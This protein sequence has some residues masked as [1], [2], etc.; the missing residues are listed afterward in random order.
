MIVGAG[1]PDIFSPRAI[2]HEIPIVLH[3]RLRD[4]AAA[5]ARCPAG[6]TTRSVKDEVAIPLHGEREPTILRRDRSTNSETGTWIESV[7]HNFYRLSL[8]EDLVVWPY[9]CSVRIFQVAVFPQ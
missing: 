5:G 1:I 4:R 3:D 9:S 6:W 8:W 2:H 7:G